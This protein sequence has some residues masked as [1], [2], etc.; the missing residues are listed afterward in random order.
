MSLSDYRQQFDAYYKRRAYEMIMNMLKDKALLTNYPPRIYSN[1]YMERPFV[2]STDKQRLML[3]HQIHRAHE[4]SYEICKVD[5]EQ[6]RKIEELNNAG[7][8][9][10]FTTSDFIAIIDQFVER[11]YL[12]SDEEV[13]PLAAACIKNLNTL[14]SRLIV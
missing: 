11:S 14:M 3:G 2:P 10:K 9:D 7:K 1:P 8:I 5:R 12:M 4:G 13:A 6:L